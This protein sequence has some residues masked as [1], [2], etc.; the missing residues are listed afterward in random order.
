M[1]TAKRTRRGPTSAVA[2]AAPEIPPPAPSASEA[3]AASAAIEAIETKPAILVVDDRQENLVALEVVLAPLQ[4]EVVAVSSGR[5][6]LKQLLTREFAVILL[7]VLMPDMDGFATATLVRERDKTRHVPII[8]LTAVSHQDEYVA[9]GYGLGAVDYLAKPFHPDVLRAK[10]SVFVELFRKN[11]Q[12]VAQSRLLQESERRERARAMDE[13]RRLGET[14]YQQLAESMPQIVWTASGDGLASYA[15]RRWREYTGMTGPIPE[16]PW[17]SVL[18]LDDA[19][20]MRAAWSEARGSGRDLEV[21]VRLR[22][23]DGVYRWHLV[24]AVA[25][26][27]ERGAVRE[28]IGTST[29]VDDRTRAEQAV[30]FLADASAK[31]AESLEYRRTLGELCALAT[32]TLAD[33]C[34]VDLRANATSTGAPWHAL[35]GPT[36]ELGDAARKLATLDPCPLSPFFLPGPRGD[37]PERDALDP[38]GVKLVSTHVTALVSRGETIG[39]LR[40][41]HSTSGRTFDELDRA[42]AEELAHRIAVAIDNARLYERA[43]SERMALEAAARTKDEFLAVLSHELRSPLHTTLGWAQMLRSGRLDAGTRDTALDTIERSVRAQVRLVD[44][45][46]DVSSI[47]TG[48]LRLRIA[49]IDLVGVVRATVESVQPAALAKSI[50]L[51]LVLPPKGAPLRGDAE[52]LQQVVWNLLTNAIKFTPKNGRIRV[53]LERQDDLLRLAVAD[54]GVGIAPEFLPFVFDRFRQAN[55][56]ATRAHGGL[57]LGLSIVRHL[58]EL[59]GGRC[60]AESEGANRGTTMTI[61]L[62]IAPTG[63]RPIEALP[64]AGEGL[65]LEGVLVLVVDDLAEGRELFQVMLESAGARVRAAASVPDALRQLAAQRPDVIVSDIGLPGQSGYDLIH[66]VRASED[67]ALRRLPAIA[68]TAYASDTDRKACLE[69]GFD[70]HVA[71][72]VDHEHLV[73]LLRSLLDASRSPAARSAPEPDAE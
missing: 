11:A 38:E 57:G 42:L 3:S 14:R 69:A 29:D 67:E 32:R 16:D 55:S 72:P 36:Q 47:V 52:R 46:L 66:H 8:F 4:L 63:P 37:E 40:L 58:V 53:V 27:D 15:N 5:Q 26:R 28:W 10:V 68:L 39:A 50:A 64:A 45:L 18:H 59:H 33:W 61:E 48:K 22:R 21:E 24:R 23:R 60:L 30:R 34:V 6:A 51:E 71:K 54:S 13:L 20:A 31:L 65:P 56:S 7:D 49:Q 43:E 25:L 17:A 62:P 12:L 9:R 19:A 35:A 41:A 73:G 1:A 44:D 2:K 70:A